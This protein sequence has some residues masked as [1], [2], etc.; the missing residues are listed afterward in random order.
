MFDDKGSLK[1]MYD[2]TCFRNAYKETLKTYSSTTN[3][4]TTNRTVSIT[5][6]AVNYASYFTKEFAMNIDSESLQTVPTHSTKSPKNNKGESSSR[7][8]GYTGK[9]QSKDKT[10]DDKR[11]LYKAMPNDVQKYLFDE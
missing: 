4:A 6:D 9:D 10:H 3:S 2:A 11:T 1:P 5:T 8:S 7:N